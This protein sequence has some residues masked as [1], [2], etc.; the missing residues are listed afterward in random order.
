MGAAVSRTRRTRP[1]R[2]TDAN[3]ARC[4]TRTCF[5][6]PGSVIL[7]RAAS[8]PMVLSLA[9]SRARIARRVG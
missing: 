9:L 7:K 2:P 6:K 4:K 3:P 5:E 1:S 8:W